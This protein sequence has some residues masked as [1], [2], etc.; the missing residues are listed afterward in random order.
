MVQEGRQ[1][2]RASDSLFR[3]LVVEEGG[4]NRTMSEPVDGFL[5]AFRC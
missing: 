1:T 2:D 4:G 3:V 5:G